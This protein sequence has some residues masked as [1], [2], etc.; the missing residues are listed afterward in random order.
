MNGLT[1]ST[2]KARLKSGR[3][4]LAVIEKARI[5]S[6]FLIGSTESELQR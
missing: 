3:T 4:L 1:M 6:L 2:L 5:A